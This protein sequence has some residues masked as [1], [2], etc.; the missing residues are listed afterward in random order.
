M[1]FTPLEGLVMGT[2]SGDL[3]P[4]IPLF[5]IEQGGYSVERVDELLN[6]GSGLRG[7]C[8][9][10]DM[11]EVLRM[12]GEGNADAGLALELFCYRIR[13]YIGAYYAILGRLDALVFTAGIG[14]HN[15]EIRH[16]CC[17]D[18]E[19]LG[20]TIDPER[21]KGAVGVDAEISHAGSQTRVLVVPT[22]EE[23]EIAHATRDCL[24][25]Q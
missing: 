5:L 4:A 17:V 2:R 14:E 7:L 16:R 12:A 24:N 23:L 25:R 1:G 3:D 9:V 20:I 15:P 10:N 18:L 22:D 8:G 11:R 19:H 13:K 6:R 21:N